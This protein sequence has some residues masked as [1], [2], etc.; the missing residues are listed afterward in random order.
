MQKIEEVDPGA[1]KGG[2]HE[3][4]NKIDY[5]GEMPKSQYKPGNGII[6]VSDVRITP[7]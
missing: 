1:T 4:Q 6:E 5:E 3:K 2:E 7:L